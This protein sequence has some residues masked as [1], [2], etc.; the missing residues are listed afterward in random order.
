MTR[1]ITHRTTAWRYKQSQ[2]FYGNLA[3]KILKSNDLDIISTFLN[4]WFLK[5]LHPNP[6]KSRKN[7]I[8]LIG[9]VGRS[10][11]FCDSGYK[12]VRGF[13]NATSTTD[14]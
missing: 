3:R 6:A 7:K 5:I 1:P 8:T 9:L 11:C 14:V 10:N 13:V 4:I 2:D 12:A